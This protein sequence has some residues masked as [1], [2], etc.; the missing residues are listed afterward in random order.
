MKWTSQRTKVITVISGVLVVVAA[1]LV[2]VTQ[3][4]GS[5]L[6]G[7]TTDMISPYSLTV[8]H[9]M[10]FTLTMIGG[11]NCTWSDSARIL[12]YGNAGEGNPIQVQGYGSGK[13]NVTAKCK[14]KTGLGVVMILPEPTATPTKVPMSITPLNPRVHGDTMYS[15]TIFFKAVN[16]SFACQWGISPGGIAGWALIDGGFKVD[17]PNEYTGTYTITAKCGDETAKSVLVFTNMYP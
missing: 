6:F 3:T 10:P 14:G 5:E 15:K 2:V 7:T 9:L 4:S 11:T 8:Q 16:T 13:T 17:I 1:A 12:A